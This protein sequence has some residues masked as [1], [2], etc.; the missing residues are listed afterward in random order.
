MNKLF[1]RAGLVLF[2]VALA[3]GCAHQAYEG[4]VETSKQI[5]VI[6]DSYTGS[7]R[8]NRASIAAVDDKVLEWS[9]WSNPEQVEVLPGEHRVRIH[10]WHGFN[11]HTGLLGRTGSV[12]FVAEA[13]HEYQIFCD[14]EKGRFK[15]WIKDLNT[16]EIVG[17]QSK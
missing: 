17:G 16:D 11:Q 9:G 5:A 6:N 1:V 4:E 14:V 8:W 13:G 10:C 3:T 15:R 7:M 12:D 2:V